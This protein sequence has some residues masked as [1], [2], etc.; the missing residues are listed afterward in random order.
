MGRL[1]DEAVRVGKVVRVDA[2]EPKAWEKAD[3]KSGRNES[4]C[5]Q[6]FWCLAARLVRC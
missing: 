6:A 3:E 4:T 2:V 5:D 1:V